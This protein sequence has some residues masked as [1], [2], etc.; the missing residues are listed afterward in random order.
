[1]VDISHLELPRLNGWG[2][3]P[4]TEEVYNAFREISCT[5][6]VDKI[7][8]IGFNAGHSTT[9]LLEIFSQ[10]TVDSIGPS[11]KNNAPY[12]L[13]N[14]Y[15]DRFNFHH[16]MTSEVAQYFDEDLENRNFDFALVDG[17]HKER[18]VEFDVSYCR[19]LIIPNILA[20]NLELPQVKKVF[21][22]SDYSLIKTWD[23]ECTWKNVT[24]VNQLGFY[25]LI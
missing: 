13:K 19:R 20:D 25:Q 1:L 24:K 23:Y 16:G 5:I 21:D 12:V 17:H 15:K 6:P 22:E 3:L 14:K 7:L 18:L 8:E 11:P 10:A 4:S 9:Y 2:F